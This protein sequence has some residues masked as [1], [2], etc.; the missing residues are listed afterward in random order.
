MMTI[1]RPVSIMRIAALLSLLG[2]MAISKPTTA[3]EPI[4][5][6]LQS[7]R[8]FT[9]EVDARTDQRK[10]WLRFGGASAVLLRPID[11]QR[12]VSAQHQGKK[13]TTKQLRD[14]ADSLKSKVTVFKDPH[15]VV[16]EPLPGEPAFSQQAQSALGAAPRVASVSFDTFLA[17]WDGDVEADGLVVQLHPISIEGRT[18]QVGGTVEIE[19]FAIQSRRFS[20]VPHGRGLSSKQ[21]GRWSV[22]LTPEQIGPHGATLKLPFQADHPEF[23]NQLGSFGLV[24]VRF[25]SPGHGVF[26]HSQDAV[27]IRPF[28]PHRDALDRATGRRFLP[29][30]RTGR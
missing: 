6:H 19:L 18:A 20:E 30:E 3:G 7:G 21:I 14:L 24:H 26:E 28:A 16:D 22:A 1:L 12:V 15:E 25:A 17:N 5:V 4:T 27:R 10:L 23:N 11:W 29:S 13:L 2:S 9:A 8:T